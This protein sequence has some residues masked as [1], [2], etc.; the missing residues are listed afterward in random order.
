MARLHSRKVRISN[1]RGLHARASAKFVQVAEQ[2]DAEIE[3]T[4]DGVAVSGASIMGLL[5]LAA[6]NGD[7]I[8]ISAQGPESLDAVAALERLIAA[9]FE[10]E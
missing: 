6:A 5:L 2:F 4:K 1:S 7:E 10:E 9:R 8:T 3:V